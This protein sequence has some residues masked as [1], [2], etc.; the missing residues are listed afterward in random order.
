MSQQIGEISQLYLTFSKQ[1]Y[2]QDA[3][4]DTTVQSGFTSRLGNVT[5]S[6]YY[7]NTRNHYIANDS[8]INLRLS[9]PLSFGGHPATATTD[10]RADRAGNVSSSAGLSGSCLR[11]TASAMPCR[12]S[13]TMPKVRRAI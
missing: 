11:T 13:K 12:C 5:W 6:L 7:Q 3:G 10:L 2:W 9:L 1:S 8:S 4:S